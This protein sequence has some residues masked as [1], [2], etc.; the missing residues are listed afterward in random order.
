MREN[1]GVAQDR[2]HREAQEEFAGGRCWAFG[3][4]NV[5]GA[6]VQSAQVAKLIVALGENDA[7]M[8]AILKAVAERH[9]V[10]V[11]RSSGDLHRERLQMRSDFMFPVMYEERCARLACTAALRP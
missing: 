9:G 10:V 1:Q 5:Y 11:R 8:M 6:A 3:A 2:A 7:G 4:Q